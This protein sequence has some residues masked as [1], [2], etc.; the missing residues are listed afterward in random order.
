MLPSHGF[1]LHQS[2]TQAPCALPFAHNIAKHKLPLSDRAVAVTG[3]WS[4]T[5]NWTTNYFPPQCQVFGTAANSSP[6]QRSAHQDTPA[7]VSIV[8]VASSVVYV[9]RLG[10][11]DGTLLLL[12]W[13]GLFLPVYAGAHG[14]RGRVQTVFSLEILCLEVT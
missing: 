12:R 10:T 9:C 5:V 4:R 6:C 8:V 14:V 2:S 13:A 3:R 7:M 11:Y 1:S